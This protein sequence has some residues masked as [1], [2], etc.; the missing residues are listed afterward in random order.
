MSLPQQF[1]DEINSYDAPCLDGLVDALL[2]TQPAVSIRVNSAKGATP[3]ADKDS[4]VW[5]ADGIY[6]ENRPQFTF[7]PAFHQGMYYVQDASSMA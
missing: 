5:C 7:D 6:F 3:P 2:T 4:V 1:I